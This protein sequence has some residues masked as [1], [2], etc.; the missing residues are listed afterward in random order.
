VANTSAMTVYLTKV[1][2][3]ATDGSLPGETED[4]ME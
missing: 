1:E 2:A 3:W 4:F